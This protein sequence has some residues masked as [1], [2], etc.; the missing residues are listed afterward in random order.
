MKITVIYY[1]LSGKT[2][3][4]AEKIRREFSGDLIE[5]APK[6]QYSTLSAVTKGC[7]RSLTGTEDPITPEKIDVTDV[8]LI[9][10]ATPVWAGRPTPVI[11]GAIHA[12]FGQG[13]KKTFLIATCGDAKSGDQAIALLRTR[14]SDSGLVVIGDA[15]LD[16]QAVISEAS[17]TGLIGKI[18]SVG[19]IE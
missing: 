15:I 4:I 16:K 9:V 1:S 18:R 2:R 11:N 13:G 7:Y 5:V 14:A 17:I 19:E 6:Q 12:L 3:T 10:L 8:D